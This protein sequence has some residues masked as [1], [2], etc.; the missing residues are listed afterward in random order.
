[1][2]LYHAGGDP[3]PPSPRPDQ[4]HLITQLLHDATLHDLAWDRAIATLTAR[5]DCLRRN[6]DGSELPD[7]SVEFR[8]TG[9]RALAVGYDSVHLDTRPSQFE[10]PRRITAADLSAWPFKPQEAALWINSELVED[11]LDSARL[12]WLAGDGPSVREAPCT[13][14]ITFEPWYG[15]GGTPPLNVQLLAAG[16]DFTVTSAGVPLDLDEWEKQFAAW[17]QGWK[18]HWAAKRG[19]DED[20]ES[21]EFETAIPAGEPEP[22]DLSY[23]PPAEPVFDLP[24]SDVPPD[25]LR[26]IRD[27]F[28]AEHARDWARLARAFSGVD[29]SV[30]ERARQLEAQSAD[31]FGRWGY[32]RAIDQW[33]QEGRRAC[34]VVR[35]VE[36]TMPLEGDPAEN[37]E[38]VWTFALRHRHGRWVIATYS[39]GWAS[40]GSANTLPARQ[41]PWLKQW[42]SGR[43]W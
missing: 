16:D 23:R 28:E 9:V 42:R 31:T 2:V 1:M 19:D 25:L 21:A 6:T 26:P 32:A 40:H 18:E 12:T 10:P 43:V 7:R 15:F 35:G 27:L 3:M 5:F 29:R 11:A 17:W 22:P 34:V 33:W 37:R 14:C 20:D 41:K 8:L 13:F 38:A 30:E 36:H 24:P 4:L 39:Q